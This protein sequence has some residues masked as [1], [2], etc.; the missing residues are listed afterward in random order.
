LSKRKKLAADRSG[1]SKLKEAI[2]AEDMRSEAQSDDGASDGIATPTKMS[3]GNLNEDD[4]NEE[5]DEEEEEDDFL[6][7]EMEEEWG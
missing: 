2:S 5:E 3:N 1:Y 6:A 7:K 4:V